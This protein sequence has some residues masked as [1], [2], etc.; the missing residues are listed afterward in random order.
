MN[1]TQILRNQA[2]TLTITVYADGTAADEGT[3]TFVTKDLDG[4]TVDTL[5][6]TDNSDGTYE[7]TIPAK[8]DL[9]FLVAYLS[10][11]SG[12]IFN[13]GYI[14]IVGNL[15]F[16]E[17]Q[18]R[19]FRD[20]LFTDTADFTDAELAAEQIRVMDWLEQQTGRSWVPRYR[21]LTLP[22]SGSDRLNLHHYR[23]SEGASGGEGA[24]RDVN[25][26]LAA[27]INDT[28][29]TLST[30]DDPDGSHLW[31]NSGVWTAPTRGANVT[32]DFEYGLEHLT[33]GVDEIA[34]ME[35]V[36]RLRPSRRD[37]GIVSGSD[38]FGNYVFE[39]QNKGRPS[40]VPAVNAWCRD[41]DLRVGLA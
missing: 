2:A 28:A 20:A 40:K 5:A 1:V 38:E 32:V 39:P 9:A 8:S 4:T 16:T 15:L 33:N 19:A 22:G 23:K 18:M 6:V 12:T 13:Q 26:V 25:T 35:L 37:D 10:F 27:T 7:V 14:E 41:N 36:S 30:I 11:D 31:R 29:V 3:A 21:R 34:M 24:T 17:A